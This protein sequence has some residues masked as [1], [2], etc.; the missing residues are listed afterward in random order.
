MIKK[1]IA[2][3]PCYLFYWIGD[4]LS[5]LLNK[6][7]DT[8]KWEWVCDITCRGYCGMMM[9]SVWWNDFGGL[10]VWENPNGVD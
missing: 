9:C 10:K 7:P 1:I 3:V 4:L 2:V 5:E 6:L 8:E